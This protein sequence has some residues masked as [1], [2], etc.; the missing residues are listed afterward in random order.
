MTILL[1]SGKTLAGIANDLSLSPETVSTYR[2]GI[3]SSLGL[4]TTAEIIKFA[5]KEGL[6]GESIKWYQI[7]FRSLIYLN[8][9][10]DRKNRTSYV[11]FT[12]FYKSG[13]IRIACPV[14]ADLTDEFIEP[15]VIVF[16][17]EL[18]PPGDTS[19]KLKLPLISADYPA[20]YAISGNE[21][22][23]EGTDYRNIPVV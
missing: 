1:A 10:G 21:G 23:F 4:K 12:I 22:Y 11:S 5:I 13:K 9:P 15:S 20:A 16:L 14:Q 18:I 6:T 3:L 7:I 17:N 19:L 8:D 2:A